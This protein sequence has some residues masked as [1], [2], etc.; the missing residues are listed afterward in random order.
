MDRDQFIELVLE[1]AGVPASLI[2]AGLL[3]ESD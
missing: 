3:D 1:R 2:R